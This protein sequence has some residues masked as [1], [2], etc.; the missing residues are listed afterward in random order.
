MCPFSSLSTLPIHTMV[1]PR[2]VGYDMVWTWQSAQHLH[3]SWGE[4]VWPQSNLVEMKDEGNFTLCFKYFSR[5]KNICEF[6]FCLI[7]S[8]V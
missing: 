6:K 7:D 1:G 3:A 2:A 5:L 8:A 4:K